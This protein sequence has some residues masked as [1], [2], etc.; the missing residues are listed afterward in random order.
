M[1]KAAAEAT[2]LK[3]H[4]ARRGAGRGM[5]PQNLIIVFARSD[6]YFFAILENLLA[7]NQMERRA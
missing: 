7:L 6:D 2:R 4:R 3:I 1:G 5:S